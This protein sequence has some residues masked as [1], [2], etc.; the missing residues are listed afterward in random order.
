MNDKYVLDKYGKVK[1]EQDLLTWA[2]WF[3]TA[4][5]HLA[6]DRISAKVWV[7]TVF[8]GLDHSFGEGEEPVLWETMIFGGRHDQATWRYRSQEEALKGHQ[9]A[10]ALAREVEPHGV[11]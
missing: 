9:R 11:R 3:E 8:L 10:V 6:K 1:P 2:R 7:S 5:R 4:N